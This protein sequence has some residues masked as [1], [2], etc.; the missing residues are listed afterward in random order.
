MA[1]ACDDDASAIH[2]ASREFL[3]VPWPYRRQ[4]QAVIP[5]QRCSHG[6]S[7]GPMHDRKDQGQV[8]SLGS[9]RRPRERLRKGARHFG[10]RRPC[11]SGLRVLR[12]EGPAL[13]D[14][15]SFLILGGGHRCRFTPEQVTAVSNYFAELPRGEQGQPGRWLRRRPEGASDTAGVVRLVLSR[16][17]FDSDA[18]GVPNSIFEDG[19]MVSLP[20]VSVGSLHRG[21]M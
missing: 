14:N 18:G 1:E 15:L 6:L 21:P 19:T 10:Q 12:R 16:K 8:G 3:D 2:L 7:F 11:Q 20:I 5:T 13:G 17:G 4:P 9:C